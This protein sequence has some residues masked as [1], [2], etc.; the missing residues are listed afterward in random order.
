MMILEVKIL[1]GILIGI[2]IIFFI[3]IIMLT[4]KFKQNKNNASLDNEIDIFESLI[5]DSNDMAGKF[6]DQL[7]DKKKL[8][9]KLNEK[10][11][12][13]ISSLRILLNRSDILL[14]ESY[15]RKKTGIPRGNKKQGSR[16]H[17][18]LKLAKDG[19]Q[20]KEISQILSVPRGEVLL[21]LNMN[22]G[23]VIMSDEKTMK[24]EVVRKWAKIDGK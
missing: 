7:I 9:E 18:I 13:R 5:R 17:D 10:L 12:K 14:S 2:D 4:K 23:N 21:T 6:S 24:P 20:I 22:R 11:D 3:Y 19:K 1:I 15:K 8:I 16:Y